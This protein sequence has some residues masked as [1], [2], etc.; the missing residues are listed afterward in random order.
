MKKQVSFI[1][2]L[3]LFFQLSKANYKKNQLNVFF[4][5]TFVNLLP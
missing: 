3:E 4:I 2:R 5:V 1:I